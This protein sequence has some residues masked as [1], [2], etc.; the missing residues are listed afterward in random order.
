[1]T[2]AEVM[3]GG[4]LVVLAAWSAGWHL[5]ARF[6][7]S[8]RRRLSLREL[9]DLADDAVDPHWPETRKT[10][11]GTGRDADTKGIPSDEN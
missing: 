3:V 7:C 4:F 11:P 8:H 5:G 6:R 2:A 10:M 9:A 1:M